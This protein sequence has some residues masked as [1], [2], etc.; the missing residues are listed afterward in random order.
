MEN[1]NKITIRAN[2]SNDF[3][4]KVFSLSLEKTKPYRALFLKKEI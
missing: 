3:F 2:L 4:H 1:V